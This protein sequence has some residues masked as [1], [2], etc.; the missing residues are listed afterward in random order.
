MKSAYHMLKIIIMFK[1]LLAGRILLILL[2][3]HLYYGMMSG[4][5]V[6]HPGMLL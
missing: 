4:S 2:R 6:V 5:S 1:I 3:R